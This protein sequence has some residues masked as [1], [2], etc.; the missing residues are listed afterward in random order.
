MIQYF[1]DRGGKWRFRVKGVNG[2]IIVT[3]EAYSS[4]ANAV[5]GFRDL[6]ATIFAITEVSP[7][8]GMQP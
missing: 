2:E 1:E 3:S 6:R 7:L 5:R 4:K 8:K